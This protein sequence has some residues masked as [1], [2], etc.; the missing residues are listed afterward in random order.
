MRRNRWYLG[1][2][3]I[4]AGAM[5][6][7]VGCGGDDEEGQSAPPKECSVGAQTGC[8]VGQECMLAADGKPA[9][10]CS[11]SGKTGCEEGLECQPLTEGGAGCYCSI[12][13]QSGC[14]V[15]LACQPVTDGHSGCFAP[16]TVAGQ[17]FDLD[18]GD[19]IEGAHVVARDVNNAAVSGVAV[20]DEGGRYELSVPAP[21][22]EDGTLVAFEV[23]LRADAADYMT[24]PSWPRVALPIDVAAAAGDPPMLENASTDIGLLGLENTT[25]LGSISGTV[26]AD[27]P[28]GTLVVAGGS[29]QGG[30]VT[31]IAD[32]DGDYTVFNVPVGSVTVR[33]YKAGL[34]LDSETATVDD[35]QV[36]E[37]VDLEATGEATAVV[38]G[39]VSMV[40]PG[41]GEA[42]S[43]ILAVEETFIEN[44]ATGEA[45]PGL[46]AGNIT[47]G[48]SIDGVPDG[49]YV[50]LAAFENDMLVR[51]P[52]TSIGGTDLARVTVSGAN[53]E[54]AEGFKITGSLEV[55]SP[56]REE[57]VSGTPSFVWADDSGED[58]YE[59]VVFDA[60]GHLVW[61][62]KD[63][64]GVSGDKQVTVQYGGDPLESGLLYQFRA[65]SIKNGGSPLSRTEDLRGV[66]LYR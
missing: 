42:T 53:I 57:E 54:I 48:W 45:P 29:A 15:G 41:D 3:W 37:D 32:V 25:G 65:T 55:V 43:V 13:K 18:S 16:V 4:V 26:V 6:L 9:C 63:V 49:K 51:D 52:D 59:V 44:V 46:R 2:M 19:A 64:P 8:G 62:K 22:N 47:S 5:C 11:P 39:K 35:G 33:G 28:R 61:E 50:V 20:S 40:N 60:Y 23:L 66:F 24:F 27:A 12:D 7:A 21:H 34:Q 30:G 1:M 10:F 56:D 58:H 36:T 38:S 14:E 17:V 31:G